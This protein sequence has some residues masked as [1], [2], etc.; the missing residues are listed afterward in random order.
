M[1]LKIAFLG[2]RLG[3]NTTLEALD[4]T[5]NSWQMFFH[6]AFLRKLSA[7]NLALVSGVRMFGSA[8]AALSMRRVIV[9]VDRWTSCGRSD[10]GYPVDTPVKHKRLIVNKNVLDL[11]SLVQQNLNIYPRTVKI[12]SINHTQSPE[13]PREVRQILVSNETQLQLLV[14]ALKNLKWSSRQND[15]ELTM[16]KHKIRSY[17]ILRG[18][19]NKIAEGR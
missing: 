19:W 10:T 1:C 18:L 2:E 16:L 6:V 9:S 12:Q 4:V 17:T 5:V 3:A 7:A 14:T 15:I 11:W 13:T 8:A